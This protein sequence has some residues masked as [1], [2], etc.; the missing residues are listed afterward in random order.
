MWVYQPFNHTPTHCLTLVVPRRRRDFLVA[1]SLS[2]GRNK[3]TAGTPISSA[4]LY[5]TLIPSS[6]VCSHSL[7][8]VL[9]ICLD[10]LSGP[11][12]CSG[13]SAPRAC[14][15]DQMPSPLN[16]GK[17]LGSPEPVGCTSSEVS[18]LSV[19]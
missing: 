7:W 14:E 12:P 10:G 1:F 2:Q 19:A 15:D 4:L 11:P 17:A 16:T 18:K 5:P 8:S 13:H 6:L 9:T 3:G